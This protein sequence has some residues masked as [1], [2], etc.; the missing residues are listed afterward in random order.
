M[1]R[2]LLVLAASLL[3]AGG[4]SEDL[5]EVGTADNS[6]VPDEVVVDFTTAETDSGR[7]AWT[8]TAPEAYKFNTRKVFLME[9]PRI[10]FY[11]EFG[12]L[13]TTLT[14]DKGE[15]FET[16]RDMLAYGNVV[17]LSMDGDV[18][19]TDSLRYVN[20]ED[21]IVSDSR[22]K[23]TRGRNITTGIGLRCDHKLSSVEILR[24]VEAT[25]VDDE[26]LGGE[27]ANG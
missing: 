2:L 13:Q 20:V 3:L 15:Y 6:K 16:S 11:D 19:E 8:L 26:S 1:P 5:P 27:R 18:L 12:N 4:C 10:D 21:R 7:V 9:H 24:D 17:V 14:S 22:V 23:I 25:I